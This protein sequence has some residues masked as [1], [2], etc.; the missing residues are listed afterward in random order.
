MPLFQSK[1]K[2]AFKHNVKTEI[3]AGKPQDQALAISYSIKKKPKKM[4]AGGNVESAKEEKRP[5]PDE[6][7]NDAASVAHNKGKKPL[8]SADWTDDTW[9]KFGKNMSIKQGQRPAPLPIAGHKVNDRDLFE[10]EQ[11]LMALAPGP[12]GEKLPEP[13]AAGG[14]VPGLDEEAPHTGE[15]AE[16]MLRRHATELAA[17]GYMAPRPSMEEYMGDKMAMGGVAGGLAPGEEDD[18]SPGYDVFETIKRKKM[19]DGGMVDLEANSEE[20]E[21]TEDDLSYDALKKEQYDLDQLDEQPMDSNEHGDERE[22]DAED[23]H[24]DS[25]VG[26]I[27]R[28]AK[29]K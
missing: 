13:M 19:A 21:N 7:F 9:Q 10:K 3:S 1:S 12:Y 24:D 27:K 4:A 18:M 5:M 14:P 8:E 16:D 17:A 20:H 25:I 11:H 23:D 15:T 22:K 29:K 28:K 26:Q 6:T 2:K